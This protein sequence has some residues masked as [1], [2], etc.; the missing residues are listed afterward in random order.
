MPRLAAILACLAAA[1]CKKPQQAP[2]RFC[3][4]DLSGLWVNASDRHFAYRFRED[5]GVIA[6]EYLERADDGGL[7]VPADAVT[8]DLHRTPEAITGVMRGSGNLSGEKPC[9]LEF[10]TRVS[11]CKP[12]ALQVVV[13]MSVNLDAQ[14]RRLPAEDGGVAAR[15]LR[16][17]RLERL[18]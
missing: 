14:C 15:D 17:F 4:Q 11:D 6:G 18:R 10:E 9:P 13:E 3:D 16:E 2:S 5:A 12:E 7:T 8:F 1:S